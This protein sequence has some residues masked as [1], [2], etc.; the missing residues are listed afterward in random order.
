MYFFTNSVHVVYLSSHS[1]YLLK[2]GILHLC[3]QHRKRWQWETVRQVEGGV[4]SEASHS[5]VWCWTGS[6]KSFKDFVFS[7][8]A[9][10]ESEDGTEPE[11]VERIFMCDRSL[12][13]GRV[14]N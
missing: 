2:K 10:N 14:I 4:S 7:A 12:W 9:R 5:A 3:K 11:Q 8:A 13:D 6:L 1:C